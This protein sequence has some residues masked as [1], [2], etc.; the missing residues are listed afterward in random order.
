MKKTSLPFLAFIVL[1]FM[2]FQNVNGQKN[3][4]YQ[5]GEE[6]LSIAKSNNPDKIIDNIA[7]N[8]KV[9]KKAEIMASFLKT[10]DI[11]F[12][13]GETKNVKLFNVIKTPDY[14][15]F[16]LK[17]DKKF[18]IVKSKTNKNLK[19]TE[20]FTI[21]KNDL[22]KNLE[23]GQKI[24]RT[25][26]YSCHNKNG[27]GGIGPNLTDPYWKFVNS[28]QDL[29]DII[30]K[31]KKG[32]MIIAYKDYLTPEELNDITLY[33]K[34]LQGKKQKKAKKPEG[35]KKEIHFKFF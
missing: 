29:Y 20:H 10:K 24:Y 33:I 3:E 5:L 22:S 6:L 1:T 17:N 34:A 32:T 30:A 31:G 35:D 19:I 4:L 25:R 15:L 28:E 7:S 12:N 26:C 14:T 16:I 2:S 13:D 11:I 18:I 27:T 8:L 21:L 9:D 23:H